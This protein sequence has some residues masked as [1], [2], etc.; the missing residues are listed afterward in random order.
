MRE[1][2][3]FGEEAGVDAGV[4]SPVEPRPGGVSVFVMISLCVVNVAPGTVRATWKR[5][6]PFLLYPPNQYVH[7]AFVKR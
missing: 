4:F 6:L 2:E 5:E 1:N 3:N 7:K